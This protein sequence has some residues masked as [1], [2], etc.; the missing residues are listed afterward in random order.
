MLE[1]N[2]IASRFRHVSFF[3]YMLVTETVQGRRR[4]SVSKNG[5][6]AA[7]VSFTFAEDGGM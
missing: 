4:H 3:G 7:G 2:D 6:S 5:H 1:G